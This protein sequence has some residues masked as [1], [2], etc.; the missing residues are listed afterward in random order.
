LDKT[1]VCFAPQPCQLH[2]EL[3]EEYPPV[4]IEH[5]DD[6]D[7]ESEESAD[8]LLEKL[9]EDLERACWTWAADGGPYH[10]VDETSNDYTELCSVPAGS[11]ADGCPM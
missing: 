6:I 8:Y 7:P 3:V 4:P 10:D 5:P 2:P 9:P 1:D 11:S